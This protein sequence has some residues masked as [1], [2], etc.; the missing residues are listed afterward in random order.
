MPYDL[1][2][3]VRGNLDFEAK[4][5]ERILDLVNI[6]GGGCLA[7]FTSFR[8]MNSAFE[9]LSENLTDILVLK[10]G[11]MPQYKLLEIFKSYD[12]SLLLGS[13]S[14]WQGVDIPGKAL[15]LLIITKLPFSAPD[16]P[17][18]EA[19]SERLA[20]QGLN[21]F[22]NLSLPEA[23]TWLKQGFGRLIRSASDKGV[24]AILDKR[25]TTRSYGRTFIKALPETLYTSRLDDVRKFLSDNF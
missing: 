21:P 20:S 6:S 15:R 14:F 17:I 16:D 10:Q 13:N 25:L 3:P 9:F 5:S 4:A 11:D 18:A 8:H 19:R 7:L 2:E 12:K 23:V 24:A 1:P 22:M